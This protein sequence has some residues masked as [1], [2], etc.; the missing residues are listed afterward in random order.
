[1]QTNQL[2]CCL[3]FF[4]VFFV[5]FATSVI[6]LVIAAKSFRFAVCNL[7]LFVVP[8]YYQADLSSCMAVFVIPSFC[9]TGA[10]CLCVSPLFQ[11]DTLRHVISQT[12]GYSDSLAASQMYSP[13][14][15]NVRPVNNLLLSFSAWPSLSYRATL[16]PG[17]R[18]CAELCISVRALGRHLAELAGLGL[19]CCPASCPPS[20][21][22]PTSSP[23]CSSRA[24]GGRQ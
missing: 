4:L 14:G 8:F 19:G 13:Q 17:R 6:K 7:F 12:G 23:P 16:S 1:M 20:S 10:F 11:V 15:I 22:P 3:F 24:L 9:L 21:S 18:M 2:I 5:L